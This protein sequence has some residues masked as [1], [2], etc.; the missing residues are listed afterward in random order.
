MPPVPSLVRGFFFGIPNMTSTALITRDYNGQPLTFRSDGWFNMT[1]AAQHFGKDLKSFFYNA[2]TQ[3]YMQELAVQMGGKGPI[4]ESSKGR[5]GGTWGH[6]KLAV[7]FARWLDVRF[8]VWCDAMIEDIVK[9]AAA[10]TIVK[11]VKPK[12]SAVMA[13]PRQAA[14]AHRLAERGLRAVIWVST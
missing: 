6:P 13:M 3:E 5:Y 8:S 12:E 7:F 2:S 14:N 11:P 1:K 9:G 10:V 4:K